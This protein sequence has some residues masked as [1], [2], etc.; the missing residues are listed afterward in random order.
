MPDV[1]VLEAGTEQ[2]LQYMQDMRVKNGSPLH[3]GQ[4]LSRK[5]EL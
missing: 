4:Q 3:M 5:R 1:Q 2:A